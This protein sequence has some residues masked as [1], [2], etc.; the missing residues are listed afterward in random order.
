MK[1]LFLTVIIAFC[2]GLLITSCQSDKDFIVRDVNCNADTLY[3]MPRTEYI[4]TNPLV[5]KYLDVWKELVSEQ[6]NLSNNFFNKHITVFF[7]DTSSSKNTVYLNVGF[8][9]KSGWAAANV[10]NELIIKIQNNLSP[11]YQEGIPVGKDLSIAQ[12]KQVDRSTNY[13]MGNRIYKI[14]ANTAVKY[15]FEGAREFLRGKVNVSKL[16]NS[17]CT[18][19]EKGN[20]TLNY[21]DNY[22]DQK[23]YCTSADLDLITGDVHANNYECTLDYS[24]ANKIPRDTNFEY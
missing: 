5:T 10:Y 18:V 24:V 20:L 19:N 4:N 9:Y 1:K 17:W 13:E 12:I 2:V 14:S 16:C 15:D 21:T 11:F 23:Q 8:E 22:F 3:K 7:A 6:S